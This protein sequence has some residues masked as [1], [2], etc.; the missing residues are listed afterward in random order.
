MYG[1][2]ENPVLKTDE[3]HNGIDIFNEVGTNVIAV[4]DG[5][6]RSVRYS[7]TY[8]NVLVYEINNNSKNNR[9]EVFYGHLKKVLVDVGDKVSK[10]EVVGKSGDTGLVTGPHLHYT[11]LINGKSINP[12]GFVKLSMTEEVAKDVNVK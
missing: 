8:G 11:I 6:V 7:E 1:K 5:V 4:G 10:G 2:R 3:F 12:L 9:I